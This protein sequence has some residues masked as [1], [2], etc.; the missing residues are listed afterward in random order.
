MTTEKLPNGGA[1]VTLDDGMD[2]TPLDVFTWVAHR[3]RRT[4][5]GS[6]ESVQF[7]RAEWSHDW[8][9]W[10][11]GNLAAALGEIATDVLCVYPEGSDD[12]AWADNSR[13]WAREVV[14]RNRESPRELAEALAVDLERFRMA[15]MD[16]EN[17]REEVHAFLR[18]GHLQV[19]ARKAHGM[20]RPNRNA[21]HEPL[22]A[23]VFTLQPREVTE[24]GWVGAS[25]GY[26][27]PWWDEA[28]FKPGD[29]LALWPAGE[30]IG[31]FANLPVL[32][33]EA[34]RIAPWV[35]ASW[36]AFGTLDTPGHIISHRSFDQGTVRLPSETRAEHAAR[37]EQ[38][39]R[40]DAAEREVMGLLASGRINAKGQPPAEEAPHE[41]KRGGHVDVPADAFLD[42]QLAFDPTGNLIVRIDMMGRLFPPLELRGT[43]ASPEFPLWH[44]LLI[45]AVGLRGVWGIVDDGTAPP[46]TSPDTLAS[47]EP[48]AVAALATPLVTRKTFIRFSYA[49][50]DALLI[51]EMHRLIESGMMPSPHKAAWAVV[52]RAAGRKD[53]PVSK[54]ARLCAGYKKTHRTVQ[55]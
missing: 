52:D 30:G 54:V 21:D 6:I 5:C 17:A 33:P 7:P 46:S 11:P 40:F 2:W 41:V 36:R 19:W 51:A 39:R 47:S 24:G 28:R 38:H 55:N 25:K 35:A 16:Y 42:R 34:D 32:F 1:V 53:G 29:V 13:A 49:K 37:V 20:H 9:R 4:H 14:A 27:G 44:D 45:E 10:P 50:E 31:S 12:E 18:A 22:G 8:V 23:G 15:R 43:E 48:A 3:E 26:D